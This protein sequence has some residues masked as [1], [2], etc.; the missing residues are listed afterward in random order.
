MLD[1][2][3]QEAKSKMTSSVAVYKSELSKLRTGRA[4]PSLLSHIQVSYYGN[5]TPLS[6]VANVTVEDARTLSITPWE[7]SLVA[8]IEKAIMKSDLGLNPSTAGTVIRVP[9]PPLTEERRRELV[10]VVRDETEKAKI[11]VRNVRRDANADVKNLHKNKEIGDDQQHQAE[12]EIQKITDLFV[13]EIDEIG[14]LKEVD[15]LKV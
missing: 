1:L 11:C 10:K 3:Y 5:L 2:I 14:K 12:A 8:E 13:K 15:L 6:Q 7:K 4:H 9:L